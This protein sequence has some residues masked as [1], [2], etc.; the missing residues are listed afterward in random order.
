MRAP[1]RVSP[2][3]SAIARVEQKLGILPVLARV[4]PH[5]QRDGADIFD[6]GEQE[7]VIH[8]IELEGPP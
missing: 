2:I 7:I 8:S 3:L 1:L 4:D 5:P 6:S